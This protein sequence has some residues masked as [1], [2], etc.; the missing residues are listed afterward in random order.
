MEVSVNYFNYEKTIKIDVKYNSNENFPLFVNILRNSF[1]NKFKLP[2]L[3]YKYDIS[4][5]DKASSRI[6]ECLQQNG[7]KSIDFLINNFTKEFEDIYDYLIELNNQTIKLDS[8]QTIHAYSY[9]N[10]KTIQCNSIDV[11][12]SFIKYSKFNTTELFKLWVKIPYTRFIRTNLVLNMYNTLNDYQNTF[13]DDVGFISDQTIKVTK[14]LHKNLKPPYGDCSDYIEDRP[15]N[16]TNQ[17]HCFRQCLKT[18]AENMFDCKPVVIDK[19]THELDFVSDNY[20]ECNSSVQKLFD[21]YVAQ[22]RI[23]LKCT[24]LCPRDCLNI[25]FKMTT[26]PEIEKD[27]INYENTHLEITLVWDT[28][29]PMFVYNEELVMS[30]IDYIVYCGGVVGLLFGASA[31]DIIYMLFSR[32]FWLNIWG[33]ILQIFQW[34]LINQI[35]NIRRFFRIKFIEF[36]HYLFQY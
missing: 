14:I 13:F 29:Q 11:G 28:T 20:I 15:F 10:T 33:I 22:N 27:E 35:N 6:L 19:T 12:D 1:N 4:F 34:H 18:M 23:N 8:L 7:I 26:I 5:H 25:D 24:E 30:F 2:C 36:K 9:I 3:L 31:L 16:G 17:W 21:E 32:S